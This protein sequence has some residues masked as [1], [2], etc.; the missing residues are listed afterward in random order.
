MEKRGSIF[1]FQFLGANKNRKPNA[2]W[3]TIGVYEFPG[4]SILKNRWIPFFFYFFFKSRN[5][6]Y[7]FLR[8]SV[9]LDDL[10]FNRLLFR[11]IFFWG[12][13]V[14]WIQ[15]L[16]SEICDVDWVLLILVRILNPSFLFVSFIFCF[17][18]WWLGFCV[19]IKFILICSEKMSPISVFRPIDCFFL[20]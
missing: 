6:S 16:W 3:G 15:G 20:H 12:P 13:L 14:I 10:R 17:G 5:P 11:I 19:R 7:C 1:D 9:W 2:Q 4:F 18:F 8:N